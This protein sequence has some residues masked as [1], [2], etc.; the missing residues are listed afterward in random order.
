MSRASTAIVSGEKKLRVAQ[1]IH[2]LELILPHRSERIVGTG[3]IRLRRGTVAI[4]TKIGGDHMIL[5]RQLVC[6]FVP[7]DMRLR[8]AVQQQQRGPLP[9]MPDPDPG[10]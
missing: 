2:D 5:F 10:A 7:A 9:A 1:S 8:I 6:H 3:F 4:S